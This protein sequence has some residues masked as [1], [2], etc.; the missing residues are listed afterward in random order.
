VAQ[1]EED[2][3]EVDEAEVVERV[4]LIPDDQAAEVAQPSEESFDLPAAAI[5]AERSAVLR[6]GFLPVA[7]VWRDHLDPEL[8]QRG[9]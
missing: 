4:A 9:V 2:A 1:Q 8:G 6:P 7:P 5:A 3:S